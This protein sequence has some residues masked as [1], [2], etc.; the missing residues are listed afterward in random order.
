MQTRSKDLPL[1]SMSLCY[2]GSDVQIQRLTPPAGCRV[3]KEIGWLQLVEECCIRHHGNTNPLLSDR[4]RHSGQLRLHSSVVTACHGGVLT[5]GKQGSNMAKCSLRI[6]NAAPFL[7][8]T[9]VE[10]KK[11]RYSLFLTSKYLKMQRK[12]LMLIPSAISALLWGLCGH[13][14]YNFSIFLIKKQLDAWGWLEMQIKFVWFTDISDSFLSA[15]PKSFHLL[16]WADFTTKTLEVSYCHL[17]ISELNNASPDSWFMKGKKRE[18]EILEED[19][20]SN[21]DLDLYPNLVSLQS[22]LFLHFFSFCLAH[23]DAKNP[24]TF[25]SKCVSL[26]VIVVPTITVHSDLDSI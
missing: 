21:S 8:W 17:K 18:R 7:W 9:I 2:Q 19:T 22:P 11:T 16:N 3:R 14:Q 20:G 13:T 15:G 23:V 5:R 25:R 1:P 26:E 10:L 24:K 12:L 6:C 4:A